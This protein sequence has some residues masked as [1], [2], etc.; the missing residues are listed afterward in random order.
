MEFGA[1]VCGKGVA[2]NENVF[3]HSILY[4]FS[5]SLVKISIILSVYLLALKMVGSL[6]AGRSGPFWARPISSP[7]LARL[8]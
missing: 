8:N 6:K 4:A 7:I 3:K 1:L 2:G 5:S